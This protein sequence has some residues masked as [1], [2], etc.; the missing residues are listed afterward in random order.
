MIDDKEPSAIAIEEVVSDDEGSSVYE[1]DLVEVVEDIESREE[2]SAEVEGRRHPSIHVGVVPRRRVVSDHR[3]SLAIIIIVYN[4]R[5]YIFRTLGRWSFVI[6]AWN[7][8]ILV[9]GVHGD[10]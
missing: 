7:F 10:R 1:N 3:R 6:R 4:T 9:W 8:G 5:F 2:K